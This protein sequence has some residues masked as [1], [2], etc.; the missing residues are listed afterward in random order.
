MKRAT[1]SVRKMQKNDSI[2]RHERIQVKSEVITIDED[3][4]QHE[5]VKKTTK[6]SHTNGNDVE[7]IHYFEPQKNS[8]LVA[9]DVE[10]KSKLIL[11]R[12]RSLNN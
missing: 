11:R 2:Q 7:L 1:R 9:S 4:I 6:K 10:R 5:C 8:N 12:S 3:E